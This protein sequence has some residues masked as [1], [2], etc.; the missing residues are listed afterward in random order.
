MGNKTTSSDWDK[1]AEIASL[2]SS[3]RVCFGGIIKYFS[4]INELS[5]ETKRQIQQKVILQKF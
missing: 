1:I 5:A 3:S 2:D 4:S